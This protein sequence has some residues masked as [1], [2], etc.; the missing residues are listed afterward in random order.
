[1]ADIGVQY[2]LAT[3]FPTI[4]FNDGIDPFDGT[5]K[6]YITEIRGLES[7]TLRTPHDPVPL[8]DGSLIHDFWYGETQI[9]IEG[10]ILVGSTAIEDDIVVIRN[11]MTS[12]L[13]SALNS[14]L[15]AY[16]TFTFTPQGQGAQSIS[17]RYNV[18]LEMPHAD[19]YHSLQFSF[20][21]I[22]GQPY[23]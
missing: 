16:G 5:D 3:G 11:D 10:V 6:Y 19:N 7:P 17:V 20:G 12:D 22:A 18:G 8:G 9:L 15:R 4:T 14:I 13:K 23:S 21:L 2:A 1:M